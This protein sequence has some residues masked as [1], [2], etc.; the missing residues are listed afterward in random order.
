MRLRT[1]LDEP[2]EG[3]RPSI[4]K[5]IGRRSSICARRAGWRSW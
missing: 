4:I 3:I 2:T 5:D 1:L